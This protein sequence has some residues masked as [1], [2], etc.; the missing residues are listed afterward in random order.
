M[1][2]T[3]WIGKRVHYQNVGYFLETEAIIGS[4]ER[5]T[6]SFYLITQ[7]NVPNYLILKKYTKYI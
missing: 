4:A 1:V 5:L 2:P 7:S 3:T 6:K